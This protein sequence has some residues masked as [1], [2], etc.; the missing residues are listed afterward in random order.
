[1]RASPLVLK[2]YFTTEFRFSAQPD[3]NLKSPSEATILPSEIAVDVEQL[4]TPDSSHARSYQI[5]VQLEPDVVEK[6]PWTFYISLVGF[7]EVLPSWPEDQID[8][9][10]VANAP[11]LLYSAARESLSMVSGH[12]P[13]RRALLPSITFAPLAEEKVKDAESQP[14]KDN[15]AT[16]ETGP[17]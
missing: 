11:A 5:T 6:F 16:E 4:L 15:S 17:P 14:G 1:M 2:D 3:F 7:F 13:Y 12:G 9:L 8:R 10:F